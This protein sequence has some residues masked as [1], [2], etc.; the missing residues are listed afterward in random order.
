MKKQLQQLWDFQSVY[1][2][3]RNTKP[4][5]INPTES[6][7]R[8]ELGKEE[9]IE[10]LEAC[11][12]DDL[13][14]VTDALADQLY[15]LLGTMVAHGMQGIIKDVF[16]EVH[17]SNMSKLGEDGKPIYREDGKVLKGPNYSP[18]NIGKFLDTDTQI[19]LPFNEDV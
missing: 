16:N 19:E 1:D 7:L 9:L 14:E 4:T 13:V 18:P 5:L 12:N 15:I 8:Y 10:Y 2:Q 11:N 17:R 3:T 6:M